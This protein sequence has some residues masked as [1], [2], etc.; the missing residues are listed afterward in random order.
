MHLQQSKAGSLKTGG[1]QYWFEGEPAHVTGYLEQ[2]KT[3]A[4]ILMTPYGPVETPFILV[5][6]DRKIKRN[7]QVI[8]ANAQHHRIQKGQSKESIGEAI[9][10]WFG[11]KQG[12]DF[13]RI[14]LD[15]SR[16]FDKQSRLIL[17][18]LVVKW[19][20]HTRPETLPAVDA[21]L[22]FTSQHQSEFWLKQIA[23]CRKAN[24]DALNWTAS[25]LRRFVQ[26][27]NKREEKDLLRVAGAL[28]HLGLRLGPYMRIGYDCPDSA[29][30]FLNFPEYVCP[31]E[32]KTCSRGFKYQVENYAQLPRAVILCVQHNMVHPREHIDVI[33]VNALA[34][35]FSQ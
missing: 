12:I 22:S 33:E 3:C 28:D 19:R 2:K 16:C 25:Q 24:A 9:R 34:K 32:I 1:P 7:G 5:H 26:R 8:R 35:H 23:A 18:P 29:F 21:P 30:Q 10:H 6:R 31:V 4:V 27:H 11:L 17:V 20:N 14:E 15:D 13:E